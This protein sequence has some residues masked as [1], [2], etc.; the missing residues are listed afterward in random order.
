MKL[1]DDVIREL[2]EIRTEEGNIGC[3]GADDEDVQLE[4]MPSSDNPNES[5]VVFE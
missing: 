3:V 2:T 5:V 4:V 1:I